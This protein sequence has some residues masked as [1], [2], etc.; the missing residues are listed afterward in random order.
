MP[1]DDEHQGLSVNAMMIG[2]MVLVAYMCWALAA[3]SYMGSVFS[4]EDMEPGGGR[5]GSRSRG[6]A[7]LIGTVI[8]FLLNSIR[9]DHTV[10]IIQ[11]AF[12]QERWILLLFG[13]L[14]G[15]TVLFG[16]WV[17]KL[18]TELAGP[19]RKKKR[20]RKKRKRRPVE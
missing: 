20:K 6:L 14:M 17:K 1:A 2:I 13:V 3:N 18:E 11:H 9:I 15:C 10:G 8:S 12:T 4:Y 19:T 16:L 7:W 5:I